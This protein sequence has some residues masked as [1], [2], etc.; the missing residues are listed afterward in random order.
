[1]K[2]KSKRSLGW[3]YLLVQIVTISLFGISAFIVGQGLDLVKKNVEKQNVIQSNVLEISEL[4][5]LYKSKEIILNDYIR[6]KDEKYIEQ[7]YELSNQFDERIHN[8]LPTLSTS[9]QKDALSHII[10]NNSKYTAIITKM[11]DTLTKESSTDQLQINDTAIIRDELIASLSSLLETEKES[12][13]NWLGQIYSQLK[14]NSIILVFSIIISSIVALTLVLMVSRNMRR[15]LNQIVNMADQIANKDL[16]IEDMEY[17]EDDEIGQI[18]HSMNRMKWTLRKMMEQITNTSTIVAGQSKKLIHYTSFVNEES[19]E[20]VVTMQQS[21]SLSEAQAHSSSDLVDRMSHFSKQI[22]EVVQEKEQSS[23]HAKKMLTLTEKGNIYMESSIEQMSVIDK[24]INQSLTLVKGVDV[25]TE[26]IAMIVKVIK[27]I[28]SQT[29]LLALNASIEAAK[30][31]ESGKSFS[32]VASEMR[33]LSEQVHASLEHINTIVV[34]IQNESKNA[35]FSLDKGYSSVMDGRQLVK[36]T[37]ETF[38]QLKTE[39]DQIGMQIERMS[40]SLDDVMNQTKVIHQFLEKTTSIS[41]QSAIGISQVA[42]TAEQFNHSMEEVE[43][44]V[45]FLDQEMDKLNIMINQFKV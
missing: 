10:E 15:S 24:S 8:I 44:S 25:K 5:S 12:R 17:Y 4:I 29:N 1:M 20:I 26:Q 37:N 11:T 28:A 9:E 21:A 41:E 38:V 45:A 30:A 16:W 6:S 22:E 33:K 34:D 7:F 35:L 32:V 19:K 3:R 40:L 42:S 31:G 18:S 23:I 14:G 27:D 2:M 39:I 13:D 36:T 43:K